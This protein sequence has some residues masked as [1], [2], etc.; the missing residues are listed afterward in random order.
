MYYVY[1]PAFTLNS[2]GTTI[3]VRYTISQ[4]TSLTSPPGT[5]PM[6][7]TNFAPMGPKTYNQEKLALDFTGISSTGDDSQQ[8]SYQV[9]YAINSGVSNTPTQ[10]YPTQNDCVAV[11]PPLPCR[12]RVSGQSDYTIPAISQTEL[13]ATFPLPSQASIFWPVFKIVNTLDTGYTEGQWYGSTNN[14]IVPTA[15][16]SSYDVTAYGTWFSPAATFSA[17]PTFAKNGGTSALTIT[18]PDSLRTLTASD[19]VVTGGAISNFTKVS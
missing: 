3:T 10:T 5:R 17:S 14:Y 11:G 4:S 16:G 6:T 2:S 1:P 9:G 15:G 19:L 13:V 8:R 18:V 7:D 12:Y